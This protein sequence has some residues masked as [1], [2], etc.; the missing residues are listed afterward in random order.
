M[1]GKSQFQ[2]VKKSQQGVSLIEALISTLVMGIGML[3]IVSLQAGALQL[4]KNAFF[5]SQAAFLAQ[6]MVERM[7]LNPGRADLYS[8]G[9]DDP[10]PKV[11]EDMC[12]TDQCT[13][14]QFTRWDKKLWRDAIERVFP[15]GKSAIIINRA[16]Q[17][18]IVEIEFDGAHG[19]GR[20]EKYRLILD[21]E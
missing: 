9:I 19:K 20:P 18:Y 21:I 13:P 8:L 2:F 1:Q 3:G 17:E 16:A 12:V 7:K 5:H 15:S 10:T 6:D 4:N 14:A 11:D